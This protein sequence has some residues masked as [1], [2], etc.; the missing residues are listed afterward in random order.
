MPE[1][2]QEFSGKSVLVTGA[3]KGIGRAIVKILVERGASV[4]AISR[5]TADL[6]SLRAETGCRMI[7]ADLADVEATRRAARDAMPVDFQSTAPGPLR[8]SRSSTL[9]SKPLTT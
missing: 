2:V 5:T 8:C 4:V 3:G 9:P 7:V 1:P 6:E